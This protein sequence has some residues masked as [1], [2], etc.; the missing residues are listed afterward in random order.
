M[1]AATANRMPHRNMQQPI[2]RLLD[3]ITQARGLIQGCMKSLPPLPRHLRTWTLLGAIALPLVVLAALLV[4]SA[5]DRYVFERE[6]EEAPLEVTIT[7]NIWWW[8]VRYTDPRSGAQIVSAN[9]LRIP[10][11]RTVRLLLTATDGI[12]SFSVPPLAGRVDIVPGQVQVMPI[13]AWRPAVYEGGCEEPTADGRSRMTLQVV[14]LAPATFDRWLAHEARPA[15][16]ALPEIGVLRMQGRQAFV[17]N[18]CAACHVVRGQAD[19]GDGGPDLTHVGRRMTL[20]AGL[21]ANDRKQME[22]FITHAAAL[23]PGV[24]M[25][26]FGT[27]EPATVRAVAAYLTA[28]R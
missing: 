21:L 2:T 27:M 5:L 7:A 3:G 15:E 19:G 24:G 1:A 12:H 13:T 23:K 10:V 22:L 17:D 14:A 9:E 6:P 25:P 20:A 28:L 18:G 4:Y 8:D 11:G 26:S 16:D